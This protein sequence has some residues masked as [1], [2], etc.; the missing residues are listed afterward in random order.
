M[1]KV[2]DEIPSYTGATHWLNQDGAV[3]LSSDGLV[4]VHFWAVSCPACHANMPH[5]QQLRDKYGPKGLQTLAVHMPRGP[6]DLD[7]EKVKQAVEEMDM[8][9]PCAID[10][11][12]TLGDLF[13]VTA[14]PTYFLFDTENKLRRQ[15][16]GSFGVR[17]IEQALIRLFDEGTKEPPFH[18][19]PQRNNQT[20]AVAETHTS[21][22]GTFPTQHL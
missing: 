15:A 14:W 4:L 5:L 22:K 20:A 13:G 1:L 10:A 7:V 17:M 12:H 6:F 19:N 8:R 16:K 21:G 18:E 3:A 9:E 2:G 11:E